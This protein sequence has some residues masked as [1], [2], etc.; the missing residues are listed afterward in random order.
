MVTH[1]KAVTTTTKLLITKILIIQ[2]IKQFL[3][4][5]TSSKYICAS[6]LEDC[7]T[8]INK[9]KTVSFLVFVFLNRGY[10]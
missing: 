4:T 9:L 5:L 3:Q 10:M 8:G 7:L 1:S 6:L 2:T